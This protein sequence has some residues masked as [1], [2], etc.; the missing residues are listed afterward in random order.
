MQPDGTYKEVSRGYVTCD[1]IDAM[2]KTKGWLI[3]E[4]EARPSQAPPPEP[5]PE[6]T[7]VPTVAP[8]P[9]PEPEI[10]GIPLSDITQVTMIK[11][12]FRFQQTDLLNK[13]LT[14]LE[15]NQNLQTEIIDLKFEIQ[16]LKTE[17]QNLIQ[18]YSDSATKQELEEMTKLFDEAYIKAMNYML[19]AIDN[20]RKRGYNNNNQQRDTSSALHADFTR[21]TELDFVNYATSIGKIYNKKYSEGNW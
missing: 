9:E 17:N 3:E 2:R 7:P 20:S 21:Q 5:E 14:V 10:T 13:T 19:T 6:P 16:A 15:Q 8:E 1:N 4:L 12:I 18:K 11:P